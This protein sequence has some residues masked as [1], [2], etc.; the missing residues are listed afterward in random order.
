MNK[1]S[2]KL[3]LI[4]SIGISVVV[5]LLLGLGLNY[6]AASTKMKNV[7][8]ESIDSE[9]TGCLM[10][11][12][13]IINTYVSDA[14]N[15][16][17]R[18]STSPI[19]TD[20]IRNNGNNGIQQ[21]ITDYVKTADNVENV[22]I[23]DINSTVLASYVE[24]V[25]GK[26]LREGDALKQL[27]DALKNGMYN[28]GIMASKATGEQCISMYYPVY[29]NGDIIGYVG[30]AVYS[31]NLQES[32]KNLNQKI[33]LIDAS[34][35][36]YI[37]SEN[38]EMIGVPVEDKNLINLINETSGSDN[39]V[40]EIIDIDGIKSVSMSQK[41]D[42]KDWIL[43]A[44]TPYNKAFGGMN[45]LSV[46][47]LFINVLTLLGVLCALL[48]STKISLKDITKIIGICNTFESLDL[49]KRGK[50]KT[51]EE[52]QNEAGTISKSLISLTDSIA[53]VINKVK[54]NSLAL[55][56]AVRQMDL[57]I[58]N[59]NS[60]TDNVSDNMQK[61]AGGASAQANDTE[62][63][64]E[65]VAEIGK[66][67]EN[68]TN[69]L[70]VFKQNSINM[71]SA[72]QEAQNTFD[73]LI[74]T[75]QN[76]KQAVTVINE[77]M[78]ATSKATNEIKSATEVITDIA[79]ETNLLALNASIEAARAGEAGK[80]FA[81]VA[82]QIKKLSEQSNESAK[83]IQN[84]ITELVNEV[85]E[86]VA[87]I[88]SVTKAIDLQNVNIQKTEESFDIV[89]NY[90]EGSMKQIHNIIE[91]INALNEKRES[92]VLLVSN[93][94]DIAHKNA[95]NS[96]ESLESTKE[97]DNEISSML[98]EVKKAAVI[99]EDLQGKINKFNF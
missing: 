89:K 12:E 48:I 19:V 32:F 24:P 56:N 49:T 16:L 96:M 10:M 20:T 25:I 30:A 66:L 28:T 98:N 99:A 73:Y 88:E 81:V 85:C 13:E 82:D 77:K 33:I 40:K 63:A 2:K 23:S 5:V 58:S 31:Q 27:Q 62:V 39:M 61:I 44:Y 84:T 9:L 45:S 35:G 11:Q 26:T 18:F 67:I 54:E 60:L 97:L 55:Q 76:T 91:D 59:A 79:E 65:K 69:N 90:I 92:V 7:M 37:F 71:E 87:T 72:S 6:L 41:I 50:L 94:S 86:S 15:Y 22:Y 4:A 93:L 1:K 78:K 36:N 64:S 70:S 14:E 74:T 8:N 46:T 34:S 42:G 38:S 57:Y 80:G 68:T 29:D 21:Y 75:S 51:Y 43:I 83:Q 52:Y 95:S 53:T 3:N 17:I 47:M